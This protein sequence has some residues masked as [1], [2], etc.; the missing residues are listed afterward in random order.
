MAKRH[1]KRTSKKKSNTWIRALKQAGYMKK[2]SGLL[3]PKKGT[4]DYKKVIAIKNK[5]D[6]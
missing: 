3:V 1:S 5:L 2:G 6:R 4:A